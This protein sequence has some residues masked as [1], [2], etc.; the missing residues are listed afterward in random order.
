MVP[1]GIVASASRVSL[2]LVRSNKLYKPG[3]APFNSTGLLESLES[4]IIIC[5]FCISTHT[6]LAYGKGLSVSLTSSL[7][8][9]PFGAFSFL[10]QDFEDK[11]LNFHVYSSITQ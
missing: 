1:E 2:P 4:P 6:S 7:E 9:P 10:E 11:F 3:W 5:I 8:F